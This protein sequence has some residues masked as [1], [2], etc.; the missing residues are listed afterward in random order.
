MQENEYLKNKQGG[1]A[2]KANKE[3]NQYS[4]IVSSS[5]TSSE[6]KENDEVVIDVQSE[7]KF[8]MGMSTEE[9]EKRALDFIA[10]HEKINEDIGV[11]KMRENLEKVNKKN[12]NVSE[13]SA[14]K[15]E[16]KSTV[17]INT[18]ENV[19]E[20]KNEANS[21][22]SGPI[23]IK[24]NSLNDAEKLEE[25]MEK[26]LPTD[27][28]KKRP[29]NKV[30]AQV[31][32]E[33]KFNRVGKYKYKTPVKFAEEI[34]TGRN[35]LDFIFYLFNIRNKKYANFFIYAHA[36]KK[37]EKHFLKSYRKNKAILLKL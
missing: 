6:K 25:L 15:E 18:N 12:P 4:T 17:E 3:D 30:L 31:Q 21:E 8:D 24:N 5:T 2:K 26:Y 14:Q 37:I 13:S 11:K 23:N 22:T 27:S 7:E 9:I 19:S 36:E 1:G 16:D 10:K 20:E 33:E 29:L 32:D 28:K 34:I 35:V